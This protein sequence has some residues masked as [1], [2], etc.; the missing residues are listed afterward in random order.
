MRG[1]RRVLQVVT[2]VG[3]LMIGVLALALIVSQTPWFRDWLRRYIVRESKQYLNGELSIGHLGGNLLFGADLSNVAVDVSGERIVAVKGVELDYNIF[4][5]ISKGFDVDEIKIDRPVLK[6]ARG[7]NGWNLARLV[8][9]QEQEA[10]RQGPMRPISLPSIEVS[11]ASVSI[12]DGKPS[13]VSIPRRIEDVDLKARLEYAPV[14][15]SLVLDH[16]SFRGSAP[17]LSLQN[18][19]GKLAVRDDNLYMENVALHTSETSVTVDGVVENYLATPV[20]K[21]TTTGTVSL[22]EIGRVVPQAAGYDLHPTIDLKADGPA[23]N[24]KLDVNIRSEAG[25]VRGQLTT[26]VQAP[27]FAARGDVDVDRL[28]LAPILR[29]PAQRT[30]LTGHAKLNLALKSAPATAPVADRMTGT[31]AFAGPHVVA[32]G[33][34]ARNV[35]LSGKIDGPKITLD[36]RA[37]AYGG[38]ATARGVIV[39]PAKG[40]AIAFDLRG[41]AE[42]VDLRNLPASTG[43][44]RLA[45][46]LSVSEYHVTGQGSSIQGT[47]RLHESTIEGATFSSGTNAEFAVSPSEIS[48]SARGAVANLDLD[49]FGTALKIDALAKPAY[50]SRINGAFDVSGSAP[51]TSRAATRATENAE[52]STISA[53]KLEAS[54]S[55]TD[56]G[57]LGGRLPNLTFDA[58]LDGGALN[59]HATG[60]FENFNPG[61]LANRKELEGRVS[62]TVDANFAVSDISAPMTPASI[63]AEGHATLNPSTLG[64]LEIDSAQVVGK[65]ANQVGDVTR[66]DIAGPDVKANASGRLALDRSN[67]SELKYHVEAINLPELAKLAGQSNVGGSATIDGTLTGNAASLVTKGTLD[68]SNLSYGANSAL[69]LNS[70]YTVTIPELQVAN[71]KVDATTDATFVKVGGTELNSVKATT[72]YDQKTL[73]FTTNLKEKTRELDAAGQVIFHP[74]HQELHLPTLAVRTQGVEWQTAPGS[75]ATVKYGRERVEFENVR[76]VSGDQS[77]DVNGTLAMGSGSPTGAIDVKANNVDLKQLETLALQNRGLSGRLN[78]DATIAGSTAAPDVT[79]RIQITN[80]GFQ[81]YQ[82]QSLTADVDY[83]GTRLGLD[84]TLQRSA[85]ERITAKGSVPTS[86]FK[87]SP[88][89]EHVEPAPGDA[90]DLQVKSS[91]INLGFV[92]GFTNQVTNVSGTLEADVHVTGSGQDPHAQGFIDI[93]DGTFGV[94]AAGETFTGLTTR[95]E[96]QRDV[97]KIPAFELLDRHHETLRVAG[98][99]ALHERQ[100]GA[101]NVTIDSD[102]FEVINN[103]LGDVQLQT[104]L[105]LTGELRRPQLV[106]DVRLDA[107]R[108]EVDK[109]LELFY[110]PYSQEALPEVVS[111]ER[112]VEGSGSAE[113]ATKS[114]LAKAGESA[115]PPG[116]EEKAAREE[117]AAAAPAGPA[118]ALAMDVHVVAPDNL[119]LR[120]KSLRPGGPTGTALGDI[121]ITVGGDLRVQKRP[122]GP[123]TLLG[124]VNTVR[125]TYDFQGRRFDLA[126]D[127]TIR[128]I[129]TP[130]INPLLDVSATRKIPDTGVEARI[131]I[132][133]TPKAPQLELTSNPPL[134]ESDVLALIVFNR[135]VNELG[136]GERSSL[137]ATAGGIATGFI[138]APLGESI[139]KA[140]DLDLFEI[141]TTTEN[142]D[143]GAAITLGQQVNQRTFLKVYQQFGSRTATQFQLEYQIARFLR[144][145]ASAS[146][147]TTGAANRINE[148]RI[149][150]AGID[151]I[152]FFSY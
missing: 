3:T 7:E 44:P 107:A 57:L 79:G 29:H 47:A 20:V 121:N 72:K 51:R 59:G 14:H 18:L 11:D 13:A 149:E 122:N 41:G 146:P 58:H 118:A 73:D 130:T 95:I 152:F 90:I 117:A 141:S 71:A 68:G 91:P 127:G 21:L 39:T 148:R 28:N 82:Y 88:T 83:K 143:L 24:L 145:A 36:G 69:D 92:Q 133:G 55:L 61:Q 65:Y 151:L 134:E 87:A 106:G 124:V 94:P 105:K 126:R 109:V 1:I 147:E 115:A 98:E 67:S 142:G 49:R 137:A 6:L 116:A 74:D 43:A 77:L 38:S 112:T 114:A 15:Y 26:D 30:N 12:Q 34:E 33:Y 60:A 9:R 101:V 48:Y 50:D 54:G 42:R 63:T 64:G 19:T 40:R 76:L 110:S 23:E 35:K 96:L 5:L 140:L 138:A 120:G 31:F 25:D 2:F 22:P 84:A 135:Q 81:D 27:N 53:M 132:T 150:R 46:N 78:A 16:V 144:A 136:T 89:G 17:T 123:V 103:E 62:G 56:S 37:A 10:D 86:L 128:F 80:G 52:P 99:L 66:F 85:T 139:G 8:K 93:K 45:T 125:G 111:A 108:V 75:E 113:E 102:N 70:Q 4:S 129:G 131:H 104:A 32:A 97:V 100:V 119:V